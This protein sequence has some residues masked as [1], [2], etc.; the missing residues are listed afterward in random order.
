MPL[1]ILVGVV[2]FGGGLMLLAGAYTAVAATALVLD[3]LGA[4]WKVHLDHGF[5]LD[6]SRAPEAG[7]GYEYNLALIAGL[8]CLAL[9]GPG[10]LSFDARRAR[11]E[12]LSAAGRA[13]L[14][15][16]KV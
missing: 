10:A 1:A 7:L 15:Y 12:E 6:W 3:M 9:T 2:E 13:R 4:V 5:F 8:L 14:R 16:G 11:A